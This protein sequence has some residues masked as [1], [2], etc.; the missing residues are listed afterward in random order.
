[1]CNTHPKL[2]GENRGKMQSCCTVRTVP[3]SSMHG[4]N[5]FN[6][7]AGNC[8]TTKEMPIEEWDRYILSVLRWKLVLNY[9]APDFAGFMDWFFSRHLLVS[10]LSLPELWSYLSLLGHMY[11]MHPYFERCIF[12]VKIVC[13]IIVTFLWYT[14][15]RM[16]A[17]FC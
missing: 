12:W 3:V 2:W 11:N 4:L 16:L 13:I 10:S 14:R 9:L 7:D 6:S 8:W 1:M 15:N 17:S 5:V